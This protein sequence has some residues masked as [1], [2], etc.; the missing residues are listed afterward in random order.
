VQL[1]TPE[2]WAAKSRTHELYEQQRALTEGSPARTLLE[3]RMNE[4]FASVTRPAGAAQ[5]GRSA[6]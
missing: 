4:I 3:E 1:H 6:P 2:S 5:V